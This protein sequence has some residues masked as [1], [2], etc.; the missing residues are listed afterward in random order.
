MEKSYNVERRRELYR[1]RRDQETPE[2][3]GERQHRHRERMWQRHAALT[4]QERLAVLHT[5]RDCYHVE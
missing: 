5:R 3:A 4:Q 1:L 2:Q